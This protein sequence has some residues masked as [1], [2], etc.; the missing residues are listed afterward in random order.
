M[1][2]KWDVIIVRLCVRILWEWKFFTSLHTFSYSDNHGLVVIVPP[3]LSPK[4][5]PVKGQRN[6]RKVF[7]CPDLR[8]GSVCGS[9]FDGGLNGCNSF[10]ILKEST[11]FSCFCHGLGVSF[12][13]SLLPFCHY[14]YVRMSEDGMKPHMDATML[15]QP[16]ESSLHTAS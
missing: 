16:L 7:G 4:R 2:V 13:H 6:M 9:R 15:L 12:S 5:S 3:T 8:A 14:P 1:Q 11:S 10:T